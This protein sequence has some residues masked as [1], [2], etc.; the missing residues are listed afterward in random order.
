MEYVREADRLMMG[1]L[2]DVGLLQR[3]TNRGLRKYFP[4][5][6]GHGIGLD[7]HESFGGYET[8]QAGMTLTV[9][10][11]IY[12]REKGIGIRTENVFT[13]TPDG[14]KSLSAHIPN[15]LW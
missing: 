3:R 14:P 15:R 6:I 4:H 13:I 2:K 11:G 8:F 1:A 10:P 5:A 9:E 12:D 7:T